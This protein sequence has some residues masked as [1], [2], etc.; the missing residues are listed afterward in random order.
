[1]GIQKRKMN[2]NENSKKM[3]AVIAYCVPLLSSSYKHIYLHKQSSAKNGILDNNGAALCVGLVVLC[4]SS[5]ILTAVYG[6]AANSAEFP[7]SCVACCVIV[8]KLYKC[9]HLHV[10]GLFVFLSVFSSAVVEIVLKDAVNR[11]GPKRF[12]SC[13][14]RSTLI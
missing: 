1:M 11:V 6:T 7:G 12:F 9:T 2:E 4:A 5:T 8:G 3:K 10:K 14:S 13:V